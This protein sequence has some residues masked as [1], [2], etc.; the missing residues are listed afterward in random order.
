MNCL[1]N[2]TCIVDSI[3]RQPICQCDDNCESL[4]FEPVCATDGKTYRNECTLKVQAC[5]QRRD[6]KVLSKGE[7]KDQ[8]N[9]KLCDEANCSNNE[10]CDI[11]L[12]GRASC[13]CRLECP[14]VYVPVCGSNS[15]TYDSICDLK[16]NACVQKQDVL[17]LHYGICGQANKCDDYRCNFGSV[18][19]LN[20]TTSEPY[21][22][23]ETDCSLEYRPVCGS[24]GLTY[25]NHCF[26][27]RSSCLKRK[28]V[29]QLYD[30]AC[31][32]CML[33]KCEIPYSTCRIITDENQNQTA[34]CAC[35]FDCD[36]QNNQSPV[37][38]SDPQTGL[39]QIYSNECELRKKSCETKIELQV[40]S[41]LS[42]CELCKQVHCKYR[43]HFAHPTT[44]V[45]IN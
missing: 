40:I 1:P 38:A 16:K 23:C 33:H 45:P 29:R 43:S 30:G 15:I 19:L 39:K 32:G 34:E 12:N 28:E 7:C 6:L 8:Q 24:D 20:A 22:E 27:Q 13:V 42:I 44:F 35:I 26:L 37:C 5:K 10:L 3:S 31:T 4:P 11:D 2:Q 9:D 17:V 14:Q 36:Q 41:D 21:C 25:T 18:C